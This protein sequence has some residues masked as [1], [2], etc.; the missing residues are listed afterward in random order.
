MQTKRALWAVVVGGS[1]SM[2]TGAALTG[3]N[4]DDHTSSTAHSDGTI[5][6]AVVDVDKVA[7]DMGWMTRLEANLKAYQELLQ[8]DANEADGTY[9]NQLKALI[10]PMRPPGSSPDADIQLNPT[11][12]QEIAPYLQNR[13]QILQQAQQKSEQIFANYR[14]KWVKQYREALAPVVR[15]VAQDKKISV[16]IQQGDNVLYVDHAV[17][18]TDAVV[19]AAKSKPPALTEIEMEHL[20]YPSQLEKPPANPAASQPV[21]PATQPAK[22]STDTGKE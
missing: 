20:K 10:A 5:P 12:Y 18:V 21:G 22:S 8:K 6:T 4:K 2:L 17:D 9:R 19:D 16:V 14:L 15:Q 7:R 1:I 3:C 11:Q 13:Q